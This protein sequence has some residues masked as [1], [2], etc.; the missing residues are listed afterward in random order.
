MNDVRHTAVNV[1]HCWWWHDLLKEAGRQIAL[2]IVSSCNIKT[3]SGIRRVFV[4]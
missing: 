3:L 4:L 1:N 2:S